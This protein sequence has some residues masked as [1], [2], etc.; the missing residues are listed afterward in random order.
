VTDDF[1]NRLRTW[2]A[3]PEN[4]VDRYGRHPYSYEALGLDQQW[5]KELFAD[6]SRRF[7]LD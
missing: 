4:Q 5:I 6:Y 2:L 1:D 7:G 3:D